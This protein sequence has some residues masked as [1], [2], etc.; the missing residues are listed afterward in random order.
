[1]VV[2]RLVGLGRPFSQPLGNGL[3]EPEPEGEEG[4]D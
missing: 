4:E 1:M 2:R 3:I